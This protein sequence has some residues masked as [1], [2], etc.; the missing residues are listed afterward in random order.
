MTEPAAFTDMEGNSLNA[1]VNP[2]KHEK[3]HSHL[4]LTGRSSAW[5]P[6]KFKSRNKGEAGSNE[7]PHQMSPAISRLPNYASLEA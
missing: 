4:A 6:L 5:L 2:K 1:A 3:A 7:D